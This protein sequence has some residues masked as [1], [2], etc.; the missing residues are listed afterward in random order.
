M[1]TQYSQMMKLGTDHTTPVRNE[2]ISAVPTRD[3]KVDVAITSTTT[4]TGIHIPFFELLAVLADV[5]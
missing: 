4:T 5:K 3:V 2:A 1:E